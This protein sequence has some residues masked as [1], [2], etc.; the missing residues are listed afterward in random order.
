MMKEILDKSI[1]I[2]FS[3]EKFFK[4]ERKHFIINFI[5]DTVAF[6]FLIIDAEHGP[7]ADDIETPINTKKFQRGSNV[8]KILQFIK[9][10]QSAARDKV[11]KWI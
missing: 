3:P 4:I 6:N 1:I 8:R 7:A 2:S 10:N 9:E 5:A 11:Y